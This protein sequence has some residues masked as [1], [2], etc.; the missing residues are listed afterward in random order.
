MDDMLSNEAAGSSLAILLWTAALLQHNLATLA[1]HVLARSCG[2][3]RQGFMLH[4]L[5]SQGSALVLQP[6]CCYYGD[7][8]NA[9]LDFAVP[10][11]K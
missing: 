5:C 9:K 8:L 7:F 11:V 4:M 3:L 2:R 10:A 6:V 1:C